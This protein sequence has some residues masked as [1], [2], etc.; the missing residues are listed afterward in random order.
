LHVAKLLGNSIS[1]HLPLTSR[2][3]LTVARVFDRNIKAACILMDFLLCPGGED[4]KNFFNYLN[5][6][7]F[8]FLC[9]FLGYHSCSLHH[10][11]EKFIGKF[12]QFDKNVIFSWHT[13]CSHFFFN[14][15]N[16]SVITTIFP[17]FITVW[18]YFHFDHTLLLI[19][20]THAWWSPGDVGAVKR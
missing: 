17:C 6:N 19:G 20:T 13:D 1:F 9:C 3:C 12:F 7:F 5:F 11:M 4:S 16:F 14:K 10:Q 8:R 18:A 2:L 15:L